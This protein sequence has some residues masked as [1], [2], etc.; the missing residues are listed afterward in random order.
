VPMPDFGPGQLGKILI[1][2]GLFIA[3]AGLLL[4]LLGHLGLFKLPG[5]I[6]VGG[7]NWRFYFPLASCILI[8][9]ILTLLFWL[10]NLFRR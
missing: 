1:M 3:A 10:I 2:A 4:L 6:E 7:K 8:S 9:A 5:D